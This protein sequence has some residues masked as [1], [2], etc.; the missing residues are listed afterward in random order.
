MLTKIATIGLALT[1]VIGGSRTSHSQDAGATKM[2][3]TGIV[4]PDLTKLLIGLGYEP[5][6]VNDSTSR[7]LLERGKWSFKVN[8]GVS[9][10]AKKVWLT[11]YVAEI[12]DVAKVPQSI[13][14]KLLQA[15][16]EY[17]PAHFVVAEGNPKPKKWL[18]MQYAIDNRNVTPAF[19]REE[20]DYFAG[21]LQD[22]APLWDTTK[23]VG[24]IPRPAS[25]AMALR[26]RQK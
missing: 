12:P 8:I 25:R 5:A 19:I 20:L 2:P 16:L 4:V 21:Q 22:S 26:V 11:S 17:G 1:I 14:T 13:L 7:I 6:K 18:K 15:N 3:A 10:N 9:S 24:A 23:W